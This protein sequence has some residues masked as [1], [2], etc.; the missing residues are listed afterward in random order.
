MKSLLVFPLAFGLLAACSG[1]PMPEDGTTLAFVGSDG[2]SD[3]I[4]FT[5][6]IVGELEY[7][8]PSEE[9]IAG[10]GT[11]YPVKGFA[12]RGR[13]GDKVDIQVVSNGDPYAT[14]IDDQSRV[15]AFN[16][17][18]NWQRGDYEAGDYNSRIE[19]TLS[20]STTGIYYVVFSD[21][22]TTRAKFV[23]TAEKENCSG[24]AALCAPGKTWSVEQCKCAAQAPKNCSGTTA[25]CGPG[26]IWSVEQCRCAAN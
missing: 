4:S 20:G 24:T 2:K 21:R 15:I 16:D 18:V 19:A 11:L 12:L 7:G 5:A 22:D 10:R 6:L 3:G 17:D 25:F 14:L 9:V 23:V 13:N 8:E 26:T 1:A